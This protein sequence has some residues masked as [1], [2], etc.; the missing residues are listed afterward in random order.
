MQRV[1]VLGGGIAGI[2]TATHL[3][4][5]L[6][7]TNAAEVLLVDHN[8]AHVWK[9]MLH[10]FA[11][12][13]ANYS[14]QSIS[15]AP[16]ATRNGYKFWPGDLCGLDRTRKAVELGPITLPDGNSQ[17]PGRSIPY[18]ILILAIGSHS[19]DFE[20]PGVKEHCY[21]ID[22]VGQAL[23]FNAALRS[24]IIQSMD[25]KTET[26]VVIIGGGA[27]GVELAAELTRRMDIFASYLSDKTPPRLRLT[28]I[29]TA[30]TLLGGFP[31]RIS[32]A[33]KDKL[34]QLGVDVR[35][36]TKVVGA[37]ERGVSLDGGQRADAALRVWAAGV[38]A[39]PI[40]AKLDGLNV[41][42]KGQIEVRPTLQTREDDSIFALGDCASCAAADGKP[43]PTTAQVA[44]QQA[45]FLASS[46]SDHLTRNKPPSEFK[47]RD[48]GSLVALGDYAAYGSLGQHGFLHGAQFKGWLAMI[49]HASL[50]RMHQLDLNGLVKGGVGWLADDLT[51][52][53]G[54]RI[55]LN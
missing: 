20:T 7:R 11:A 25:N 34:T 13:T 14:T 42:R 31:E 8:L 35:T 2:V 41:N 30:P 15:F 9:P 17:L 26:G 44:R 55:G 39:P 40:A 16:H 48:M 1:V 50:Y 27:T 37:D 43:L 45:V 54:P 47:F 3:A 23:T 51:R 32:Q 28:L 10:T 33:V 52:L 4:R 53:A 29:E 19:N 22:D 46:L 6:G 24:T 21:F 18:D 5:K 38:K 36:G 49:G 12:G